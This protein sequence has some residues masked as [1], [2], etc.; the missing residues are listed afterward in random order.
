MHSTMKRQFTILLTL[1]LPLFAPPLAGQEAAD[2]VGLW[3]TE[4]KDGKIAI[5]QQADNTFSGFNSWF[6]LNGEINPDVKDIHNPDPEKRER[7]LT[8]MNILWG[9]RFN[10][11][12]WVDG[13]VYDPQSG[14]T[15]KAK[16]WL[17]K[18][19]KNTLIFRGYIGAPIF[20]RSIT[21]TRIEEE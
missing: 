20:G 16:M 4:D 9:F 3:L 2:V 18:G 1:L 11:K 19:D 7:K 17:K 12:E 8:G 13:R 5:E 10:G 15:Y 6:I 21:W 14:K